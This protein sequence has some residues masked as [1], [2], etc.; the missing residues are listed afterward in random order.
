MEL[1]G[2][3]TEHTLHYYG[4]AEENE[5]TPII[6]TALEASRVRGAEILERG[7]V[8]RIIAGAANHVWSIE[9]IVS[10]LER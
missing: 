3:N 8:K 4:V 1:K 2:S 7:V 9:E 10:L 6:V 5:G